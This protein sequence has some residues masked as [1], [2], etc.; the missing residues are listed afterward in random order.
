M[1]PGF[2][3]K[4]KSPVVKQFIGNLQSQTAGGA[5]KS[6]AFSRFMQKRNI[7]QEWQERLGEREK[8][9]AKQ[10]TEGYG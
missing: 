6:N 8:G 7:K 1:Y 4:N 9:C 5:G 10:R 2:R 3:S